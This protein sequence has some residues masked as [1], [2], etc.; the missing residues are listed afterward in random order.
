MGDAIFDDFISFGGGEAGLHAGDGSEEEDAGEGVAGDTRGEGI[1]EG[2]PPDDEEPGSCGEHPRVEQASKSMVRISGSLQRSGATTDARA[3]QVSSTST[4]TACPVV[5]SEPPGYAH[6]SN[7]SSRREEVDT[8]ESLGRPA[9]LRSSR[10]EQ[11][12]LPE[13]RDPH[14][15][16][17]RDGHC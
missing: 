10:R 3:G 16:S 12:P 11:T 6:D 15:S 8:A 17:S 1:G 13:G 2:D 9:L 14:Q 4:V 7:R 5:D